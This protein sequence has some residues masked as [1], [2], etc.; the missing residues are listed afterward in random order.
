M[1]SSFSVLSVDALPYTPPPPE[2][3]LKCAN[4]CRPRLG[5]PMFTLSQMRKTEGT[6]L[7]AV[8]V[9]EMCSSFSVLLEDAL[10]YTSPPP[11]V[12]SKRANCCCLAMPILRPQTAGTMRSAACVSEMRSSFS[13]LLEDALPYTSPPLKVTSK[14]ASCCCLRL[15][16]PMFMRKTAS[17]MRTAACVSEMCSSFSVLLEDALPYT[18]PPLECPTG[19]SSGRRNLQE[20]TSKRANCCCLAMPILRPQTAGTMRSAACVSLKCVPHFLFY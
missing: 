14:R 20:V 5:M 17:T 8:C 1:C 6:V 2:V 19:P 15:G 9:S 12:T 13:V 10:P 3:A 16:M 11:K 7:I 18:P 4:C